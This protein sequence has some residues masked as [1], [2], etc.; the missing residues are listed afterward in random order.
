MTD[1]IQLHAYAY[2]VVRSA[3][4]WFTGGSLP[5]LILL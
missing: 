2:K 1:N 3:I 5:I 4:L